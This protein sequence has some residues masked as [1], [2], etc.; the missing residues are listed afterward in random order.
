MGTG[1]GAGVGEGVG[2]GVGDVG[3]AVGAAVGV[4]VGTG[5]GAGVGGESHDFQRLSF[6]IFGC[7]SWNE[8]WRDADAFCMRML[9]HQSKSVPSQA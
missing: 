6:S 5:V 7:R 8:F 9:S 2:T 1:V 3:V 4:A